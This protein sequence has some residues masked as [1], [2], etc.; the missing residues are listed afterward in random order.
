MRLTNKAERIEAARRANG[1]TEVTVRA[2]GPDGQPGPPDLP[3]RVRR[4]GDGR[5]PLLHVR[6]QRHREGDRRP[7]GPEGAHDRRQ[8]RR[9]ARRGAAPATPS[10]PTPTARTA[11]STRRTT[12]GRTTPPPPP[13]NAPW[14]PPRDWTRE[15]VR[16]ALVLVQRRPRGLPRL[17]RSRRR[18]SASARTPFATSHRVRAGWA[19]EPAERQGRL[20]GPVPPREPRLV[21]R[22]VRL[23][24]GGRGAALLRLRQRDRGPR[25]GPGL[26]QGQRDASS[27]STRPSPCPSAR[28]ACSRSAPRSSTRRATRTRTSSS[29]WRSRTAPATSA[30]PACTASSPGRGATARCSRAVASSRRCA[31]PTSRRPGTWRATSGR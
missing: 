25:R 21:L 2:L 15:T 22:A 31:A 13:K 6:R 9:H 16:I 4:E 26:L 11:R 28:G 1:D 27:S 3:P 7:A 29:T 8:R 23:R 14:I 18:A 12:P 24:L 19:F 20:H 17:R 30:R 10:C 5:D